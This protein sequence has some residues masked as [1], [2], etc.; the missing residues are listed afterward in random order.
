MLSERTIDVGKLSNKHLIIAISIFIVTNFLIYSTTV[1]LRP[2]DKKKPLNSHLDN[3]A[4][5][6]NIEDIPLSPSIVEALKLDDYMFRRYT[7]GEVNITLYI[8]YYYSNQ[9]V[10]SAHDPMV[11]FPGQGWK[12]TDRQTG[13]LRWQSDNSYDLSYASMLG[14]L[15]QH[16]ELI[17]YWFQSYDKTSSNTFIQ[18]IKLLKNNI[19]RLSSDNAFC[20]VTVSLKNTSDQKA[21]KIVEDFMKSM[22]PAFLD[23]IING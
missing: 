23:Y 12:L 15:G 8:G 20:R 10:G 11:C 9:K 6:K 17:T 7:N 2:I 5:W 16:R 18:K 3:L 1:D 4:G 21:V 22:Y 19:L 13:K 14:D